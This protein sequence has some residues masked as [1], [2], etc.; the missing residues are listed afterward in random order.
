MKLY[1]HEGKELFARYGI[2]V[3]RG[4][5]VARGKPFPDVRS[6]VMV[7]AQVRAHDRKAQGGIVACANART[8]KLA[9]ARLFAKMISGE[10]IL[11]V[12]IEQKLVARAEYYIALSYDTDSRSPVLMLSPRGGTGTAGAKLFPV[13]MAKGITTSFARRALVHARF[14]AGDVPGL[15]RVSENLGRLFIAEAALLAE[16]NPLAKTVDGGFVA[17]DAKVTIDDERVDPGRRRF[18]ELP[19]DIAIL[20]SGGGASL[21]NIDTLLAVG[22]RPANYTEYSGNPP[23]KVVAELTRRVLSRK[24]L[25]GCWVVGGTANFT[26]IYETM[27]GFADGLREVRPKPRYPFVIRRDG[28]RQAEAFR[29]L[30]TI[31]AR[32]KF[33]FHLFDASTSMAESARYI[34]RL[35]QKYGPVRGRDRFINN[36]KI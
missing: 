22:G 16:I 28:P 8:A 10:K 12:L 15:I 13:D 6:P 30:R 36:K 21:L 35:A 31:A 32:H 26:D 24:G 25:S 14:P 2:P 5:L 20:A 7:K 23:A 19:G 4:V 3:P 29:M 18:I 9:A 11:S 27:K 33:D 17:L 34:A 1:E